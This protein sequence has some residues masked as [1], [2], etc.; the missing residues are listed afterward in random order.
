[1]EN[2]AKIKNAENETVKA[3]CVVVNENGEV[4]LVINKKIDFWTFPKGHAETGETLEEAALREVKEETG[5][6]V[7][8]IKRL[9][10]LTYSH[11]ETKEKIRVAM[12]EARPVGDP[13][14]VEEDT[15]SQWFSIDAEKKTLRYNLAFL[16]D[17]LEV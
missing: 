10:D 7:Q 2:Q 8:I 11:R 13:E 3:G 14:K 1:M 12:F 6:T 9:S 17:E 15:Q 16:L 4:L 5:Y